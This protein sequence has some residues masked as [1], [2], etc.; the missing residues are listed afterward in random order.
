V[1]AGSQRAPLYSPLLT[2]I[3]KTRAY[4]TTLVVPGPLHTSPAVHSAFSLLLGAGSPNS[5]SSSS[6]LGSPDPVSLF[7]LSFSPM[8]GAGL[9]Y[10]KSSHK[11]LLGFFFFVFFKEDSTLNIPPPHPPSLP[12]SFWKCRSVQNSIPLLLLTSCS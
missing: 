9:G 10:N 5:S 2:V 12:P 1:H 4:H 6:S 3:R 8:S 11:Y 7:H